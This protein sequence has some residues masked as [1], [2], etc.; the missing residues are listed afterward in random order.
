MKLSR[1]QSGFSPIEI[2]IIIVM[3]GLTGAVGWLVYD[4]QQ[5]SEQSSQNPATIDSFEECV[6]AGNPVMES[7]PEQ[8]AANGKTYVNPKQQL[9]DET[10]DW[11]SYTDRSGKYSLKYPTN[12]VVANN[13]EFCAEYLLLLGVKMTEDQSSVGKCGSGGAGAFGQVSVAWRDD[14]SDLSTCGLSDD[15]GWKVDSTE[16]V[17]VSGVAAVKTTGTYLA[18]DQDYGGPPKNTI[19]VQ[20]CLVTKGV[21]YIINYSKWPQYPDALKDY[22]LMVT[23]TLTIK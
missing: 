15:A 17:Q 12:W 5:K 4:R 23:K 22:N 21:Q 7:Y 10:A 20:Y 8:C 14:R 18:D 1:N 16:S 6:A 19:A 2:I 11:I 3:I 9:K 13:L